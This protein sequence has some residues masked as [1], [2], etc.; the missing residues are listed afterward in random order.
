MRATIAYLNVLRGVTL[1]DLLR[2][3]DSLQQFSRVQFHPKVKTN[4]S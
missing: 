1:A 3:S 4:A 2:N